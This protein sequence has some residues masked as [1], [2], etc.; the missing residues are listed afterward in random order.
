MN[1]AETQYWLSQILPG[2]G[3][4]HQ[5]TMGEGSEPF[6]LTTAYI[7][8]DGALLADGGAGAG[9]ASGASGASGDGNGVGV[10]STSGNSVD[11]GAE[12]DSGDGFGHASGNE[13][14]GDPVETISCTADA[15]RIDT[16]L[17]TDDGLDLRSE[18]VM[19]AIGKPGEVEQLTAAAATMLSEPG[20]RLTAQPGSYLP[21]IARRVNPGLP[22][23]HG[24]LV[25]PYIWP[26]GVP[27]VR[28]VAADDGESVGAH[29]ASE[30]KLEFTHP[31]RMTVITQLIMITQA[32]FL[33]AL[34]DGIDALQQ[35]LVEAQVDIRDLRRTSAV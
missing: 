35:K 11:V 2:E 18:V 28:E 22:V 13:F 12:S 29:A 4:L 6:H 7:G 1:L 23:Q 15:A 32:E 24:V 31:G 3:E 26:D 14:S 30:P 34:T 5:V 21:G 8:A 25:V 16:G 27:H 17:R 9:S 33:L 20:N 19:A 10:A